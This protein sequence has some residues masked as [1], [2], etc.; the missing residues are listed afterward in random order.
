[1]KK[2]VGRA[3][4]L[5][6]LG[7][8]VALPAGAAHADRS[9]GLAQPTIGSVVVEVKV[10]PCIRMT[11]SAPHG[12]LPDTRANAVSVDSNAKYELTVDAGAAG[13]TY[14]AAQD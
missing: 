2:T 11:L 13:A 5:V 12:A 1:M 7:L 8:F 9:T 10:I 14:T 4:L 3:T 6:A